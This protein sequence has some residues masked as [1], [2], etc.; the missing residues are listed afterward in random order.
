M[1]KAALDV[2]LSRSFVTRITGVLESWSAGAL[3][4]PLL[5]FSITPLLHCRSPCRILNDVGQ[6]SQRRVIRRPNTRRASEL[7]RRGFAVSRRPEYPFPRVVVCQRSWQGESQRCSLTEAKFRRCFDLLVFREDLRT[8]KDAA[9]APNNQIRT[10]LSH[11]SLLCQAH[12]VVKSIQRLL[13][14]PACAH[15]SQARHSQHQQ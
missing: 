1:A 4:I 15:S 7:N 8:Q 2:M 14:S 11:A 3:K 12:K 13:Q 9:F 6:R 10:T 5:H